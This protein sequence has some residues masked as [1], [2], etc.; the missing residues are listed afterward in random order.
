MSKAL[1]HPIYSLKYLYILRKARREYSPIE[2]EKD[3]RVYRGEGSGLEWCVPVKSEDMFLRCAV[4]MDT[5]ER[6][7]DLLSESDTVIEVGAATGEYTAAA[8][9]QGAEVHAFEAEPRN[10]ACLSKNTGGQ[11][12]IVN[13]A[14]TTP[15]NAGEPMTLQVHD[16]EAFEHRFT[17]D[18][19]M[20]QG[21]THTVSV[22]TTTIADYVQENGIGH[23]DVLKITV[24][25]H[26]A[27]VLQGAEDVL[28]SVD[29]V[30][31]NHRY[32]DCHRI[33]E[34]NGFHLAERKPNKA[35]G[36]AVLY[37]TH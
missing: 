31:L 12:E 5:H 3:G 6:F 13:K 25:G 9:E 18:A 15:A 14:A 1:H 24:N 30:V 19:A 2:W 11:V 28:N 34:R 27:D 4:F 37:R 8:V 21:R 32:P 10:L 20:K 16:D 29:A 22:P 35:L 7:T 23:V 26:E 17:A 33:L 36:E